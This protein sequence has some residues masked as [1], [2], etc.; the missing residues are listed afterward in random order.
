VDVFIG[1]QCRGGVGGFCGLLIKFCMLCWPLWRILSDSVYRKM[2]LHEPGL[3]SADFSDTSATTTS[4]PWM[5]ASNSCRNC[6]WCL[7]Q[8]GDHLPGKCQG[9]WPLSGKCQEKILSGKMSIDYF[10]FRAM[11]VFHILFWALYSGMRISEGY[12]IFTPVYWSIDLMLREI[13][14]VQCL[15][16]S[17][18]VSYWQNVLLI[19]G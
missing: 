16:W 10:N 9:I 15:S 2:I 12:R 6:D 11:S 4:L 7:I 5:A 13:L 8:A 17:L 1:T 3:H 14:V 19:C 18:V